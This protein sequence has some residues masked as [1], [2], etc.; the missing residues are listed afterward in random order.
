MSI[1]NSSIQLDIQKKFKKHFVFLAKNLFLDESLKN[2]D[3]KDYFPLSV[4]HIEDC[5]KKSDNIDI[6]EMDDLQNQNKPCY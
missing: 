1:K 2:T 4:V 5:S 6:I 3:W